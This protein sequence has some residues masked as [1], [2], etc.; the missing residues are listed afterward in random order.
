MLVRRA[1]SWVGFGAMMV[2]AVASP[3][4]AQRRASEHGTVSQRVDGTTITLEYDRPVARGRDPLFGNVVH[5]GQSWTPGANAA[6]TIEVDK[7][8]RINGNPLPKGK[9]SVW[10]IPRETEAWS[11][12]FHKNARMFHTQHPNNPAEEQLR[13]EVKPEQG[14][15]MET[16]AWYFPVV[17]PEGTTLRMHW[18]TTFVALNVDV[19]S[20]IAFDSLTAAQRARYLGAYKMSGSWGAADIVISD[21]DGT[22]LATRQNPAPGMHATF[23]L[24]PAGGEHRFYMG[25]GDRGRVLEA[26]T[27]AVIVFLLDGDRVT[28][29][30]VRDSAGKPQWR[31][32]LVKK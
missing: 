23:A 25:A 24:I 30:E 1:S 12:I 17:G 14:S 21:A 2:V 6:T 8:V 22:L 11:V 9:Y 18:G 29:F 16:L 20:T 10:M 31:G 3:A 19:S 27:D 26:A 13:V 5:W 4:A 28:A 15:H 32:D 7:D